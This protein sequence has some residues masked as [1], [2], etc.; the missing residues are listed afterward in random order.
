MRRIGASRLSTPQHTHVPP[1]CIPSVILQYDC[2]RGN[3]NADTAG[4]CSRRPARNWASTLVREGFSDQTGEGGVPGTS[5]TEIC[6]CAP[7]PSTGER[8]HAKDM[9]GKETMMGKTYT[10]PGANAEQESRVARAYVRCYRWF[11]EYVSI[12]RPPLAV[13]GVQ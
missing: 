3:V 2:G 12:H 9:R 13:E 6:T 10:C 5:C 8:G 7:L 4:K 1:A 11:P